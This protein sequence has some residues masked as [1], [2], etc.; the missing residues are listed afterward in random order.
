MSKHSKRYKLLQGKIDP[1]GYGIEECVVKIKE[2]AGAKFDESVE[3]HFKLGIDPK[4]SEQTVK[5]PVSL[6]YGTGKQVRVAVFTETKQTEAKNN[7]ADIVGGKELIE[8]ITT[9]GKMNFSAAV[10]T[11][12]FMRELAKAAKVLGPKGLMPSPKNGTVTDDIAK[13]VKSLKGGY[14]N[15]RNDD[16]GNVHQI[17]G[18][19]SWEPEKLVKNFHVFLAELKKHRPKGVKGKF[20]ESASLCTTMGPAVKVVI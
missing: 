17:I 10:A 18:K 9:S 3:V 11:P 4:K 12:D 1:Q 7:G 5:G 14:V 13:V 2:T 15:F 8:E 16:S 20:I 6:P 19:A